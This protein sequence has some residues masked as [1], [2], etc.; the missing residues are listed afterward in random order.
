[1]TLAANVQTGNWRVAL[2]LCATVLLGLCL[3]LL[4]FWPSLQNWQYASQ[5]DTVVDVAVLPSL[6]LPEVSDSVDTSTTQG[7]ET[8]PEQ[9][10]VQPQQRR[11]GTWHRPPRPKGVAMER[12]TKDAYSYNFESSNLISHEGWLSQDLHIL[13]NSKENGILSSKSKDCSTEGVEAVSMLLGDHL[14]GLANT[15]GRFER[16]AL[17]G[18]ARSVRSK[19]DG[20][21]IDQHEAVIRVNR[22]PTGHYHKFIGSR[23]SVYFA[24]SVA[25]GRDRF[26][27]AGYRAQL[28]NVSGSTRVCSYVGGVCNFDNLVMNSGVLGIDQN[29]TDKYPRWEPGWIPAQSDYPIGYMS[30]TLLNVMRL[31]ERTIIG[32]PPPKR[33]TSGISAFLLASVLCDHLDVYGMATLS[34]T[35]DEHAIGAIHDM[36]K[37]RQFLLAIGRGRDLRRRICEPSDHEVECAILNRILCSLAA[38]AREGKLR[39]SRPPPTH[40]MIY[41]TDPEQVNLLDRLAVENSARHGKVG[42]YKSRLAKIKGMRMQSG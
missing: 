27:R 8:Q 3:M 32:L 18:G 40:R 41:R 42:S 20:V 28:V 39:F 37:E 1:M 13:K 25:D 29:W 22:L 36:D 23:T 24:G 31:A 12:S 7:V 19:H 26:V 33:S 21:T 5:G 14:L 9:T 30:T 17:V 11:P 4:F 38:R 6:E 15:T 2:S 34:K 16:C 35:L 10:K